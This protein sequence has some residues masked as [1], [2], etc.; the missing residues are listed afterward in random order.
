MSRKF[1][2]GDRVKWVRDNA[3]LADVRAGDLGTVTVYETVPKGYRVKPDVTRN[4][5]S[6]FPHL[7]WFVDENDI[8]LVSPAP[9]SIECPCGIVKADCDYHR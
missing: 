5:V 1:S 7:G 8:V 2:I 4:A 3:M 9:T 6:L